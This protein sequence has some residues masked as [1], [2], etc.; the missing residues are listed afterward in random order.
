MKW[1]FAAALFALLAAPSG[2][3]AASQT[4]DPTHKPAS[5]SAKHSPA[6]HPKA[7]AAHSRTSVSSHSTRSRR[8]RRAASGPSY[9]L[10]PDAVRYRQIQQAL[11]GKGYF[12]GDVNGVWGP[13]SESA[14][15]RFQTDR[16]LP[17]DGH[18]S[19]LSLIALGLGPKHDSIVAATA[20]APPS[21]PA[22]PNAP[23]AASSPNG[24][25]GSRP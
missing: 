6:A 14:L 22:A 20:T 5:A 24:L 7:T 19:A 2:F 11:A 8:V 23:S 18:I 15:Q 21:S 10:H 12:K 1:L 4:K 17:N 16:K 3:A 13:D 9:Q 25:A